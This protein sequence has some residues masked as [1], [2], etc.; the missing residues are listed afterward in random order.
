VGGA[1]HGRLGG[2]EHAV[3]LFVATAAIPRNWDDTYHYSI[4]V[5]YNPTE[6][7]LLQTG[8]TYDSSP[9]DSEDRTADMP[10]DRQL[11]Y[12]VGAQYQISETIT[13]GGAPRCRRFR[14]AERMS[15]FRSRQNLVLQP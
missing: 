3:D 12:A 10:I 8:F 15:Q 11:R 13:F 5:H 7:W 4:G 6:Q 9:V 14:F 2:L 1:R